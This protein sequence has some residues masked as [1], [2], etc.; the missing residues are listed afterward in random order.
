M[1]TVSSKILRSIGDGGITYIV[2][3]QLNELSKIELLKHISNTIPSGMPSMLSL[4]TV[5]WQ[6]LA[7]PVAEEL[8][9][10]RFGYLATAVY[11]VLET[12]FF[13]PD[14]WTHRIFTII[15]AHLMF[16]ALGKRYGVVYATLAH[17]VWNTTVN[18]RVEYSH[19]A[20]MAIMAFIILKGI[21]K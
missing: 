9:K 8:V 15:P 14:V 19:F 18:L 2:C 7:M 13:Y 1:H 6:C 5:V 17:I 20:L 21:R 3:E 16:L 11:A 4:S 12:Y 10:S